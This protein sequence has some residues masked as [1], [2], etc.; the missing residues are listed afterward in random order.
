LTP[1]RRLVAT[2]TIGLI[3][4]AGVG[5]SAAT[6]AAAADQPTPPTTAIIGGEDADRAYPGVASLQLTR[7]STGERDFHTCG[8]T[9]LALPL[10][11]TKGTPAELAA[12]QEAQREAQ[13]QAELHG[14]YASKWVQTNAH[15]VTAEDATPHDPHARDLHIRVGSRDRTTGGLVANVVSVVP[16]E[17][18]DWG[19]G[20]DPVADIA[21]LQLDRWLPA[22]MALA[23]SVGT[24]A[25]TVRLVGWG[26]TAN[27]ATT[28][29]TTLQQLDVTLPVPAAECA[30]AGITAGEVCVRESPGT[31]SCYGDSGGGALR[32]T[33]EGRYV[34]LASVSR[35]TS[36][37][38]AVGRAVYTD[39]TAYATWLR[40]VMVHGHTPTPA[41]KRSG[42]LRRLSPHRWAATG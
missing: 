14:G 17:L 41:P 34:L 30:A 20:T 37:V 28:L 6:T 36:D 38:C 12:E 32:A 11:R 15:C 2:T 22:P 3:L 8:A 42:D 16:H 33:P 23:A 35:G 27:D 25:K 19:T 40:Y 24:T 1:T 9:L 13:R 10:L 5:T 21:V 29:P 4:L 39:A 31:G 26:L 7:P 18:W